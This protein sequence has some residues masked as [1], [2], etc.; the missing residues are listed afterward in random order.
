MVMHNNDIHGHVITT[1]PTESFEGSGEYKRE[2][3][4][5]NKA[6]QLV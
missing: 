1:K 4:L 2:T 6:I 3:S 5:F